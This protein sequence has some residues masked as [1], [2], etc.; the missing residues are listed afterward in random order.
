MNINLDSSIIAKLLIDEKGSDEAMRLLERSISQD[1]DIC[2]PELALVE[3]GNVI[4][5]TL[6][7]SKIDGAKYIEELYNLNIEFIPLD[8]DLALESIKVAR[9]LDM[10]Y[11]DSVHVCLSKRNG[12]FLVTEDK[13]LLKKFD[14][15]LSLMDALKLVEGQYRNE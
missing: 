2:S 14:R 5:K 7:R 8:R 12:S 15:S 9:N 6:R 13:E 4:W 3:V 1:I 10:T 11:Y